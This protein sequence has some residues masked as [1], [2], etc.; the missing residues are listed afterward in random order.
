MGIAPIF[1]GHITEH[2][3]VYIDTHVYAQYRQYLQGLIGN[4][5]EVIVRKPRTT[6]SMAF[7]RYFHAVPVPILAEYWGEDFESAKLLILGEWGGWHD[8][9]DGHRF[10]LKPSSSALTMEEFSQL[11][12]WIPIWAA[13]EFNVIIPLPNESD[14]D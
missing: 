5:I 2:G 1:R 8:T 6:R 14:T 11:V 7:N 9:K 10:P 13:K 3:Q 4:D 12:D